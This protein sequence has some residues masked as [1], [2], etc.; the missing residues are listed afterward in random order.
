MSATAGNKD[1]KAPALSVAV[2]GYL[3]A[4]R[5]LE[6]APGGARTDAESARRAVESVF[7]ELQATPNGSRLSPGDL[8]NAVKFLFQ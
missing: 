6:L 4:Q 5:C 2:M 7:D 8:R 3:L 1:V